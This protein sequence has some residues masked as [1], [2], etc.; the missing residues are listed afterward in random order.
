MSQ[1]ITTTGNHGEK[2][3]S[4]CQVT[5]EITKEG[6]RKINVES[7]VQS[8]YGKSNLE[9]IHAVLDH[10]EIEHCKLQLLDS[11][12]LRFVIAARMEAA[13]K[14]LLT[15]DKEFLPELIA[16]NQYESKRDAFR[17]SRLYLPGNTPAMM[18]NAGIHNP[19]GII[20]DLEDSVALSKKKEAQLLVRNALRQ[21]NF[22][23]A[24][25]MVRINQ[26]PAG[27]EDLKYVV[28]HNVHVIL[29]PKCEKAEQVHMVDEE[30]KRLMLTHELHSEIYYMPII[31]SALGVEN[32]F[33]IASS[34]EKVIA[35]ALGLEDLTADLGVARTEAATESFY[36][37]TRVVNAC[38]A[39][40]KQP[41]DSVYSDV[42]N[43]EGL[44][45]NVLHSK[46]LGFEGMGCIH[47]RQI[48]VIHEGFAPTEEEIA[49]ATDI[50]AAFKE[51]EQKGLGVVS[52]GSKMID[53]PV[54]K[55]AIRILEIAEKFGITVNKE[56]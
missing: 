13:I 15:T 39:A 31:E 1:K 32:A 47:P 49:K 4:D 22:Y 55:R 44:M 36:A 11:G 2:V 24:E 35:L 53:P 52:L 56:N 40:R 5:L 21:V 46:S 8:M 3:R 34:S 38:K 7:K 29:I 23:G 33:P 37:R 26:V 19:N 51:A 9:L 14:Q 12:A 50:A 54:V 48:R 41:I 45:E 17:F 30:V 10:F 28:P 6:G 18:L 43:M 20:L 16:E 25:R 42:A 27:I